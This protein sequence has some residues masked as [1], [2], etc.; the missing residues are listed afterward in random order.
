LAVSG[1]AFL[2]MLYLKIF[3]GISFIMTPL[4]LMVVMTF[5]IAMM[6]ILLGLLAEMIMRTFYES[7]GKSVYNI[8]ETRNIGAE[9]RLVAGATE[10]VGKIDSPPKYGEG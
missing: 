7:Q 4:P 2:C 6:C 1:I 5:M 10:V 9:N 3:R 8:R